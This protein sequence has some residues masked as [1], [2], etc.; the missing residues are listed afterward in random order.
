M[1]IIAFSGL[2]ILISKEE[3]FR[4]YKSTLFGHKSR[5]LDRELM[6]IDKNNQINNDISSYLRLLSDHFELVAA[7]RTLEYLIRRYK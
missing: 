6:G 3:R 2:E 1:F 4:N 7:R 5:E